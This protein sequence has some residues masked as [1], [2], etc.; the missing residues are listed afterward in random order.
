MGRNKYIQCKGCLK[1]LRIDT[2]KRHSKVCKARTIVKYSMK[3]CEICNKSMISW[4]L[5][6]HLKI[7]RKDDKV[8]ILKNVKED[9]SKY[10]DKAKTGKILEEVIKAEEIEP[11]SLRKEYSEALNVYC[12]VRR[13]RKIDSLK[14]WQSKLLENMKPSYREI[15]WVEGSE[16]AEGK[17]WFQEYLEQHYGSKRVFRTTVNKNP[18]SILHTLSKRSLSLVDVFIFNIPRSFKVQDVPYTLLEDLKDGQA[19]T[20]KYDSKV[21]RFASPNVVILFSNEEPCSDKLSRDRWKIYTI[22]GDNLLGVEPQKI[23]ITNSMLMT[24]ED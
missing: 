15:I 18:E 23:K 4:H 7:H 22:F 8:D 13:E 16:G 10:E 11:K 2:L 3:R 9:Q 5:K 17:S 19:I 20:S 6:R 1:E 24:M 21:L 12:D 14:S